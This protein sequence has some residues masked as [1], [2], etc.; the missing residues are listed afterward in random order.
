MSIKKVF[1]VLAALIVAALVVSSPAAVPFALVGL[2][3]LDSLGS[4]MFGPLGALGAT[5]STFTNL[6]SALK[7]RYDDGFLGKVGWSKGAAGAMIS[8]KSWSGELVPF[9]I[10]TGNSPATS[11]TYSVAAAKSEDATY[12]Y[13]HVKQAQVP[14]TKDYGRATI[15]GLLMATASD[16]M[17][18]VY[19]KF[20]AQIDGILDGSMHSFCTRVYRDGFGC[21]GN[22]SAGT[23]VATTTLTLA[24]REDIVLFE[25]GMDLV[26]SSANELATL[27]NSGGVLTI[28]GIDY[29]AGSLTMNAAINTNTGTV[30]GDYIFQSG[31]RQNSATP[32]RLCQAGFDAWMP[33]TAPTA[34]ENFMNLGDRNN[35]G[36]L[37]G[38][39]VDCTTGTFSGAT[40]EAALIAAV[41][42]ADR[43]G[44]KPRICFM[45]PT[46]FGN[47]MVQGMGRYRPT[48]VVGPSRISFDGVVVQT[49]YGDVRVYSDRYCPVKRSYVLEWD[50]WGVYGAGTS[51]IPDFISHDGNKILRQTADDGIECRVGYYDAQGCNAP[52]NNVVIRHEV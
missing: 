36:R 12:G 22:I 26:F 31:N 29:A 1:F 19:D 11:A 3:A 8:K 2:V 41:T 49:N 46:R 50:S 40:E 39:V 21:I 16:K 51:K 20:V 4:S 18:T 23:N 7:R 52:I 30:A 27:R 43:F 25:V 48:T 10:R 33:V 44:G 35:D 13:T 15:D 32:T 6:T 45:N 38:S 42:E 9:M 5:G 34:G 14:W 37:R 28:V 47:L 24:K 17:G